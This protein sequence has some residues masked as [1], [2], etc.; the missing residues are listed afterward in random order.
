MVTP[1]ASAMSR[2][3]TTFE[4]SEDPL[5]CKRF[6]LCQIGFA[7]TAG[8][9]AFASNCSSQAEDCHDHEESVEE[10]YELDWE[11]GGKSGPAGGGGE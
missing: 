6:R 5:C 3:F 1:A 11:T 9:A 4:A 2:N 10:F 8:R 7:K